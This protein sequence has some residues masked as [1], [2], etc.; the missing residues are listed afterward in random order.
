MGVAIGDLKQGFSNWG[1]GTLEAVLGCLVT[2][3]KLYL[4]LLYIMHYSSSSSKVVLMHELW[5]VMHPIMQ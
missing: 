1:L 4:K 3:V 5:L 2:L